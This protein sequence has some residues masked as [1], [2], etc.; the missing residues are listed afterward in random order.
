MSLHIP[1][2]QHANSS[3]HAPKRGF[4]DLIA[5]LDELASVDHELSP[6]PFRLLP[7]EAL[8]THGKDKVRKLRRKV[9][10]R[11]RLTGPGEPEVKSREAEF[12]L[13]RG[14]LEGGDDRRKKGE[15][16][17]GRRTCN[18]TMSAL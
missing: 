17:P 16:G 18:A 12:L 14:D 9:T 4:P 7:R 8:T 10:T 3:L 13:L 1:Q 11:E 5:A 2:R 15:G 6:Q